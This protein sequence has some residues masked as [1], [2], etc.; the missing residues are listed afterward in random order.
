MGRACPLATGEV[1]VMVP[2]DYYIH[3]NHTDTSGNEA[4][5]VTRTIHVVDT[6]MLMIILNGDANLTHEAASEY[7]DLGAY[8]TDIV[9]GE[10]VVTATGEVNVMIPKICLKFQPYTD[11]SGNEAVTVTRLVDVVDTT[12]PVI[13]L[14]GDANLN[15]EAGMEFIDPGAVWNDLVDGNGTA[16]ATGNVNIAVPGTYTITYTFTDSSGNAASPIARLV[17]VADTTRPLITLNGDANLTHEAGYE[18]VDEGAVWDDLV[19][20]SGTA[21]ASGTVNEKVPGTYTI[22]YNYTDSSGNAAAPVVRYVVVV[23]TIPPMITLNGEFVRDHEA[24]TPY[25]ELGAVWSDLV[26]GN[27]TAIASGA[28]DVMVPGTYEINYNYTDSSG[29]AAPPVVRIIYVI[30]TTPPVIS[31]IGDANI[32]LEAGT[33]Y[34]ELGAVWSDLVDGNGT[35]NASG[36]VDINV[37]RSMRLLTYN[38]TDT[39]GNAAIPVVRQIYVVDNTPPVITLNGDANLTHEAG[40]KYIDEGAVWNDLVDGNGTAIASGAVNENV[41]GIYEITYNYTDT[42]GN[43]AIPVVR[44]IYVV[45]TTP[46]VITLIGDANPNHEAGSVYIDEGAVWN[47]LV[48]GNGTAIASGA[49][50]ENVPRSMRLL[51]IIP[52]RANVAVPVVRQVYVVDTTPPVITLIGDA[53]ITHEAGSVYIDEGRYGMTWSMGTERQLPAGQ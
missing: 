27:G 48:D 16:D 23:D 17:Y 12:H 10:G 8:W 31:L 22:T 38:Y 34:I 14:N 52:I 4:V 11:S 7:F 43:A 24:G 1:N 15:H 51:T 28:V 35:A 19:D 25:I 50:N 13:T 33:P 21:N 39:N 49:V 5:T 6:T 47:D 26:D 42:S 32:T 36:A 46:P 9:D 29:N 30:D 44:Q 37:P 2:D 45:D 40:S 18:Y 41:P 20:G 3:F 53:N